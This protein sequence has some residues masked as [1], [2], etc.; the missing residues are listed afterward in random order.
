MN[1][2]PHGKL[3]NNGLCNDLVPSASFVHNY[4]IDCSSPGA[5][6]YPDSKVHGANM[7]PTWVLLAPDGPH[8]GPMNL[9]IGVVV[10]ICDDIPHQ[11]VGNAEVQLSQNTQ[12]HHDQFD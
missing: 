9:A 1:D 12:I 8:I 6:G 11:G 10:Q 2:R 3:A 7:G 4:G 5:I